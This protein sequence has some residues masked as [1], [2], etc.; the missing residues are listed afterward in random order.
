LR[1]EKIEIIA[2]GENEKGSAFEY[3]I[4]SLL[5]SMGYTKIRPRVRKTGMEIDIKAQ[6]KVTENK[7]MCECK[8]YEKQ[9]DSKAL[10]IFFGKLNHDRSKNR[11]L[12]G[13][14]FSVSG[15]NGTAQEWYDEITAREKKYFEIYGQERIH[16][17]LQQYD[18]ISAEGALNQIIEKNNTTKLPLG[19]KYVVLYQY[20]LFVIQIFNLSGE[21]YRYLV[22]TAQG[23]I[24]SRTM[25]EDIKKLSPLLKK[26]CPI[27][28]V[29]VDKVLLNLLGIKSKT[30]SQISSEIT[31][32]FNDTKFALQELRE[33]GVVDEI[34]SEV[35]VKYVINTNLDALYKIADRFLGGK[36]RY[37][38]LS[39]SYIEAVT[40]DL[41]MNQLQERFKLN[42]SEGEQKVFL[43][44]IRHFPSALKLILFRDAT[45]YRNRYEQLKQSGHFESEKS[46]MYIENLQSLLNELVRLIIIDLDSM[47]NR[48][49]EEKKIAG[50]LL[51][52]DL[53]VALRDRL[54]F[55]VISGGTF[56]FTQ[57][58]GP[59]PPGQYVMYADD[60]S[61][62]YFAFVLSILE[63]F[64][65]AIKEYDKIIKS[66]NELDKL[67][68]AWNNMGLCF[69]ALGNYE[70]ACTCYDKALMYD[71]SLVQ[72][73]QNKKRCL[74]KKERINC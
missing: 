16:D 17:L 11:G 5:D 13:L 4:K 28:V 42:L 7:I 3:L 71:S 21:P 31:E 32:T 37:D 1:F 72:A 35:E 63:D 40:N 38:L 15:F 51:A 50:Y 41:F 60:D 67:K 61:P 9:V 45:D 30:I 64:D 66:T 47:S 14:F 62:L 29:T 48:F 39:S 19:I 57:A 33:M 56:M 27:D 55:K 73:Q 24:P 8:A 59:I 36:F 18:M 53:R 70:E 22:L 49:I 65:A 34:K 10:E 23:E 2:K 6:H 26:L 20:M 25:S 58:A 68:A 44:M 12:K 46:K 54:L 52:T 74:E 43:R 69:E